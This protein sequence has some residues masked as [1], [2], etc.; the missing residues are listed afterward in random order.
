[1]SSAQP[2]LD[3][4]LR[5]DKWAL[6]SGDGVLFAPSHPRW[7]DRPGFWDGVQWYA[8]RCEPAFTVTLVDASGVEIPLRAFDRSW[9]PAAIR[10]TWAGGGFQLTEHR[11]VL[12]GGRVVSDLVLMN[13]SGRAERVFLIAWTAIEGADLHDRDRC[14]FST[15]GCIVFRRSMEHVLLR[16]RAIVMEG[17]LGIGPSADRA[18]I[19]ESQHARGYANLP[20]WTVAPFRD[21]WTNTLPAVRSLADHVE[22]GRTLVYMGSARLAA[23]P[24]G[25][26]FAC[27]AVLALAPVTPRLRSRTAS[28]RRL[29]TRTGQPEPLPPGRARETSR[30][31]WTRFFEAAPVLETSDP[32]LAHFFPH[33]WY[34]LRLNFLSAIGQY[35]R[36]T[37]A[38]GTSVFHAA[39][40]YSA[41]CHARELRWLDA[42]R[43]RGTILTFLDHQRADGSLPGIVY[44]DGTHPDASYFAD[45]GGSVLALDEVHPDA[46]FL[47]DVY[48]PLA[49]HAE[50][51]LRVRDPDR[52]GL[53]RV[54]DPYETGQE[55]MS[56]YM[57]VD[58][59]AD[60]WHF[61]NRL[62]LL[63]VD[64]TV[65]TYRLRRALARIAASLGRPRDARAHDAIADGIADAVRARM[66]DPQTGMFSDVDPRRDRRTGVKAAVCFY[67]YLTDITG[68]EHAA[69]LE[70]NLFDP[71]SFWTPFPVPS[72][73]ADDPTFDACGRWKGVRRNCP[74]NG[75]VWPMTNC[76]VAEALAG[77][78][79]A[80]APRLRERAAELMLR[81]VRM[82]CEAGDPARPNA[83]EHYSPFTGQAAAWRGLDDYQHSWLNDLIIRWLVG[84]RPASGGAFLLDPLPSGIERMRLAR[85]VYR[86]A[87][88]T[89][90]VDAQR[91]RATVDGRAVEGPRGEPLRVTA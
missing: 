56:R 71:A 11:V 14:A 87:A 58:P 33:R 79:L 53:Y 2:P 15:D 30:R 83:C 52:T 34:G 55:Y 3:R 17:T 70:R 7:L 68:P 66:W 90:D 80:H 32:H 21:D 27:T 29:T 42:E 49:R 12:S 77:F 36:P 85:L 38:E 89:V 18:W 13:G 54:L 19:L 72:T 47:H 45:W 69:G 28:S 67:P 5:P 64:I 41:W 75:R 88:V 60:R 16:D 20:D 23:L 78:A 43:A 4:F 24:P 40:S 65:Y 37:C 63:G 57:A 39:V 82:M 22:D 76:H 51:L 31:D 44:P 50:H 35:R 61:D 25:A 81:T 59:D 91:V 86:G 6:G 9:T 1:M 62:D 46:A 26:S 48:A 74:W 73:A 84:F 8:H 10:T